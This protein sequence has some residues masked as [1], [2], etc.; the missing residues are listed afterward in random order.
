MLAQDQT[1]SD[2]E[3]KVSDLKKSACATMYDIVKLAITDNWSPKGQLA[4]FYIWLSTDEHRSAYI[5][6]CLQFT[7]DSI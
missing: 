6:E 2:F 1:V 5:D 4:E 7:E 3:H